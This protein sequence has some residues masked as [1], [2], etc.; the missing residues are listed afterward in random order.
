MRSPI[1]RVTTIFAAFM[2]ALALA[3]A[4]V[5]TQAQGTQTP[6]ALEALFGQAGYLVIAGALLGLGAV[7]LGG[8]PLVVSVWRTS[9][10]SRSLLF[11]P[12]FVSLS[13]IAC[14]LL[15]VLMVALG[16]PRP[17]LILPVLLF[18]GGTIVS[19]IA[20]NRAIRQAKVADRWLRL[21]NHL[22][23][24]VVLGMVLMLAG[25]VLWGIALVLVVSGW[26][27][28]LALWLLRA[29][30]IFLA[31]MVALW[32]SIFRVQPPASQPRP[33]DASPAEGDSSGERWGYRG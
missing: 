28:A 18:Y 31:V 12:I 27:A 5:W 16:F 19:T 24:L 17:P 1:A 8:I 14:A 13:I 30:G 32:A 7:L 25:V 20:I 2:G 29:S 6:P 33:H 11:I 9:P 23:R 10:R 3:L 26:P 22:S 4:P 15:S 21:A